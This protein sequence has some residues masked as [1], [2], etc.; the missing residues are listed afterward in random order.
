[1]SRP[2]EY[3]RAALVQHINKQFREKSDTISKATGCLIRKRV[4][5]FAVL[6]G[7]VF[8][9]KRRAVWAWLDSDSFEAVFWEA[10]HG[11]LT[12]DDHW[13][14]HLDTP[15]R[16]IGTLQREEYYGRNMK[17]LAIF[18]Q[19]CLI[20]KDHES[21]LNDYAG[22]AM[23]YLEEAC[24][25]ICEGLARDQNFK[26]V[27]DMARRSTQ[28]E[29]TR[30]LGTRY[31]SARRLSHKPN[32][33]VAD[34]SE[35]SS[36]QAR[37]A[38]LSSLILVEGAADAEYVIEGASLSR[39]FNDCSRR[40][41]E[42]QL[43]LREKHETIERLEKENAELRNAIEKLESNQPRQE[44]ICYPSLQSL[45]LESV[46][47]TPSEISGVDSVSPT[48]ID[49]MKGLIKAVRNIEAMAKN[50]AAG[51]ENVV[52]TLSNS[53]KTIS[54]LES[55]LEEAEMRA[56]ESERISMTWRSKHLDLKST[57]K[58][59]LLAEEE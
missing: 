35:A 50:I 32:L 27:G 30:E 45:S 36:N 52:E 20:M 43:E 22:Y 14:I 49:E 17:K 19:F 16:W 56:R 24:S 57:M 46:G 10:E 26:P 58:Q 33:P 41:H 8:G 2:R 6:V 5:H 48:M 28:L 34:E 40:D 47:K 44:C 15:F 42:A 54:T 55:Q 21:S 7:T 29:G 12:R 4:G 25:D 59:I 18:I 9:L 1:M 31:A 39:A 3:D 13:G 38:T 51:H 11:I 37:S 23:T 53:E